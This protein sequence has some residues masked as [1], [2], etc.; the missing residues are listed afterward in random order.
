M[1][2]QR[3]FLSILTALLF[4][5]LCTGAALAQDD[6]GAYSPPSASQ[7]SYP[8]QGGQSYPDQSGQQPPYNGQ[9]S[10]PD[11]GQQQ[12]YPS[13][14][15]QQ[16]QQDPP[17]RVARVQYMSG[18]VSTQPGGV[19]D[20][21]A[22]SQNRPLTTADRV[23]TDKNSQAELNVGDGF[24]RMNSE[25]SVTLTNVTDNSIQVELDQGT[26]EVSV[27]HLQRGEI[28]EI[29]TPNYA[30]TI[31]KNG[32]YRFD[33]YPNEDQSWVTVRSG[34]GQATGQGSAVRVNS[35]QQ[36]RFSGGTSLVH[37]AMNAPAR[38]G[39]DDWVQVRDKRLD[40]SLS[41][42]YVSPGVIGYQDLDTYGHWVQAPQYGNVWIPYSVPTGWAPYR[43]GHWAWIAPWGWTWV[44]DAPW[45]F[46]PFHYGRWVSYGGYWGWAPGPVGYW[47][48]YYAPALVGWIGGPDFGVGFGFG[49]GG[50]GV[51]VNF[52]WFPLGWGEPYYPRYC[53][54]G[55]GGWYRG[56]GYVSN[57]YI[58]NVNITN[59][60]IVNINNV[61]NNYYNNRGVANARYGFRNTAG[62]VTA[63]PESAFKSG[64]PINRVGGAVPRN[65]LGQGSMLRGVNATPTRQS[66][67]GGAAQAH[68]KPPASAFNRPV[69]TANNRGPVNRP[70]NL[71]AANQATMARGNNGGFNKPGQMGA[72]NANRPGQTNVGA[73]NANNGGR[74][75]SVGAANAN[76]G[77]FNKPGQ[78]N[79]GATPQ[80]GRVNA[81]ANAQ[82]NNNVHAPNAGMNQPGRV[83]TP[84]NQQAA[85][86]R[87]NAPT[88]S[89]GV[90]ARGPA[91]N[92][93]EARNEMPTSM[94]G[95]YVPRPPSAGGNPT[96]T[97]TTPYGGG[98]APSGNV[99]S[100]RPNTGSANPGYANGNR[101]ATPY[102]GSSTPYGNQQHNTSAVNPNT[103]VPRP[104]Q[105]YQPGHTNATPQYSTPHNAAPAPSAPHNSAP[106]YSAPRGNG[107]SNNSS[108]N[109]G[110]AMSVPRPPSGYTYRPTQSYSAGSNG[111]VAA[112]RTNA[113]Y[114]APTRSYTPSTPS[115]SA[116][117]PSYSP[118]P[119]YTAPR[120][121]PPSYSNRG[122]SSGPSYQARSAPSMPSY[123]SPA[124]SYSS[125]SMG[126]YSAPRSG[127]GGGGSYRGGG[128]GGGS[129]SHSSGGGGGHGGGGRR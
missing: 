21:I 99:Y 39:F 110:M 55:H 100:T 71:E 81:P 63:A 68:N 96:A 47:N 69:M 70:A 88:A 109:P 24:L 46:A 23:W 37:T 78:N 16:Q 34:Y 114:G 54:W 40:D 83:G 45:G 121:S 20:W 95:R 129:V 123:R 92:G 98:S 22:A 42:R 53:G 116:A 11:Q 113:G 111:N 13:Q 128:G 43:F 76:H 102:G 1:K 64:L 86:P 7:Q 107:S 52:G 6:Q 35:G 14:P 5:A 26:L 82:A 87:V 50:W 56:G 57:N 32:V 97:R 44:D 49:G 72:P 90:N 30:F 31:M 115:Y 124:P 101:G 4:V 3:R 18:Q 28:Y 67:I 62:A 91:N 126:S 120:S 61:T 73:V 74:P 85:N 89:Q 65:A 59:T 17:G 15:D 75:A 106:S 27:K 36:V 112:G 41:A 12:S 33:V 127:G 77:G 104:P 103:S 19:N 8:D 9:Q 29:D 25:T 66:V 58:R 51:S 84:A 80:N 60:R 2:L 125:R 105:T 108:R 48:P 118:T 117:R 38:D 119:S 10:Y 79:V 122:Y 93:A 94:G